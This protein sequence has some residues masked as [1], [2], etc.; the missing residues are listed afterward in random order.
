MSELQQRQSERAA[1]ARAQ[2]DKVR[3]YEAL[4]TERG[5]RRSKGR[6]CPRQVL[7]K[8]CTA[9]GRDWRSAC[10]CTQWQRT[11]WVWDHEHLWL[12]RDGNYVLTLEPYLTVGNLHL[13]ELLARAAND[14]LQVEVSDAE[15]PWNPGATLLLVVTRATASGV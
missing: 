6:V 9:Y 10:L 4:M 12:D 2:G 14:G 13:D 5:W 3:R 7:G 1:R 11:T 8:R 15:S